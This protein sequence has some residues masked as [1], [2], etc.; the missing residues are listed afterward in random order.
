MQ[1]QLEK[2]DRAISAIDS[3][4]GSGASR[5]AT[6]PKR[7]ISPASRRKMAEAQKARWAKARKAP[8]SVGV[9]KSTS[10]APVKRTMSE[11]A[12]EKIAAAQPARLAKL[13]A[14]QKKA[15]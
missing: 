15:A 1:S 4:N 10:G 11:T 7:I 14:G 13:R 2:L 6:E 12:R 9:A 3:L 8:Q 5:S